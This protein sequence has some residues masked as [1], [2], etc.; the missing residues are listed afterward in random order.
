MTALKWD[1]AMDWNRGFQVYFPLSLINGNFYCPHSEGMGKVMFS[2]VSVCLSTGGHPWSPVHGL[3]CLVLSRVPLVLSLVLSKVLFQALPV[4][5]PIRTGQRY[6]PLQ[7]GQGYSP[8]RTGGTFSGQGSGS[9]P[10]TEA[11]VIVTQWAVC[12]LRL[13]AAG[14]SSYNLFAVN[15]QRP[16]KFSYLTQVL[17]LLTQQ[18]FQCVKERRTWTWVLQMT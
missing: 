8:T 7:P 12:L 9:T 15:S 4:G 3:W 16:K 2:Q 13:P 18:F 10:P 1:C 11:Q 17:E 14:L 6:H 5:T